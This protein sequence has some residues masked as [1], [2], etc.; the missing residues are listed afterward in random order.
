MRLT[1]L[2][3]ISLVVLGTPGVA[4]HTHNEG[5]AGATATSTLTVEAVR[6]LLSGE[7]MGLARAAELNTFPGPKHV[8]EL[9]S[10]LD[11]SPM[12]EQKIEQIRRVMLDSARSLGRS[13][14]DAERALDEAFT[15]RTITE[16]NLAE[17]TTAIATLQGELRRAHL[18]A[19]L[20]TKPILTD[21]QVAKYY[22]LRQA[23]H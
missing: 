23:H 5:Q 22:E 10:Q 17:R 4:Q 21:E 7:G 20:L 3:W 9:K 6:Q 14:V 18:H 1:H 16:Q 2:L 19:H 8:L 15:R 11:L 13:I 12:Q